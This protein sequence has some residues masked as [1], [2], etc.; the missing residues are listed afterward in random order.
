MISIIFGILGFGYWVVLK[1]NNK[2]INWLTVI[3]LIITIIGFFM[4][5]LT[6]YFS[7]DIH[8]DGT[9]TN[10]DR[11]DLQVFATLSLIVVLFIQI[12]YLINITASLVRKAK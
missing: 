12:L 1:I 2:L 3:Y 5:M 6:P 4:I 11:F 7:P 9:S 10:F 8:K